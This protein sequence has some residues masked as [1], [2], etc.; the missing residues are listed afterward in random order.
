MHVTSNLPDHGAV[1]EAILEG[2]VQAAQVVIDAGVVPS[3][4]RQAG[5]RYQPET[6]GS[7]EWLLPNQVM[8]RGAGDCEDLCIW[9]AAGLR[10]TGEDPEARCT[11]RMTGRTMVHCLV[12]LGD[13][14]LY[15]PS[16]Q[17]VRDRRG[18]MRFTASGFE[19]GDIL[20]VRDH[21]GDTPLPPRSTAPAA[22]A[23]PNAGK[24]DPALTAAVKYMADQSKA[25]GTKYANLTVIT[26]GGRQGTIGTGL[27][28][29]LGDVITEA[30][31]NAAGIDVRS[32]LAERPLTS[33]IADMGAERATYVG[34]QSTWKPAGG[35]V[36]RADE[37]PNVAPTTPY[38]GRDESGQYVMYDPKSGKTYD[39]AT[40]M[41]SDY[42]Q[43]DPYT[44]QPVQYQMDPTT[45]QFYQYDPNDPYGFG[46]QYNP[47]GSIYG[48]GSYGSPY[49]MYSTGYGYGGD[50]IYH[51]YWPEVSQYGFGGGSYDEMPMSYQDLYS[52][53]S[54]QFDIDV[55]YSAEDDEDAV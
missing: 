26:P 2:Y 49:D 33:W 42:S 11:L 13:G 20:Q 22:A 4:P 24:V 30:V 6:S 34:D 27:G 47:Y 39:P 5:V 50:P 19:L 37:K 54:D 52:D 45:G 28:H 55:D 51:G 41:Y 31:A 29:G 3:S 7:E 44:G 1:I 48:Y 36:S 46:Q 40:G 53:S 8:E 18:T 17:A 38:W 15:D 23:N 9:E 35:R 12:E 32:S 10:S 25:A 14:S 16:M 43:V 21:R